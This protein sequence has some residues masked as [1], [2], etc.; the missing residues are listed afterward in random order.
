MSVFPTL[1]TERLRLRPFQLSDAERVRE[2]AG[3][4]AIADT[5]LRVPHPYEPGMAEEW[6][7]SHAE[8][9]AKGEEAVFG[10]TLRKTG[11]LVG[12]IGLAL[13]AR[14]LNAELGYWIGVPYWGQGYAT[15]AARAVLR[16]AFDEL[17][18]HR[19]HACHFARNPASGRVLER[20]G[21]RH[22]GFR[23]QHVRKWD[24]FEDIAVYGILASDF[25]AAR[26]DR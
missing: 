3:Q 16:Y 7:S 26:S 24:R 20:I 12:A 4:R 2:L 13:S 9:F 6:I 25:A 18:L 1:D 21:M 10:I 22:E 11:E 5:T 8:R 19:V 23:P 15:E 14:D 17:R